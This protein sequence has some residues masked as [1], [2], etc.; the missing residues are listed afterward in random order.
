MLSVQIRPGSSCSHIEYIL[1][2]ERQ[3]IKAT[4]KTVTYT[5]GK[6]NEKG[7]IRNK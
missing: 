4:G 3:H 1:K 5:G 7:V 6:M 2:R